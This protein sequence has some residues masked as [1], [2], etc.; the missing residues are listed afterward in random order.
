M[1]PF[2]RQVAEYYYGSGTDLSRTCFIFPNRRSMVFFRKHLADTVRDDVRAVPVTAPEMLTMNDFFYRVSGMSPAGR[3]NLLLELYECYRKLY[4]QAEPID[5]FIFWGDVILGDF[6]DVDKYLADPRP[7]FTNVAEFKSFD[8]IPDLSETQRRALENFMTHFRDGDRLKVD[9]HSDNPAVKERFVRI[10]DIMYP[11]YVNFNDSLRS[12][13]MAYEGMVYRTFAERLKSESA[14]DILSG[15]FP[16]TDLFVFTG[17]NAL[18]E[19]EKRV[20]RKMRDAG[21]A[22]FCW[23]YSSDMITDRLNKSSMFMSSNVTEFPQAFEPDGG[24][25]E[26]RPEIRVLSVPSSTGQAK[27]VPEILKEIAAAT[28]GGNMAEVGRLDVPGADTAI[29]IPDETMLMPLVNTIPEEISSVNVTMGYPMSGSAVYGLMNDIASLQVHLRKRSG[30]W[31]FYHKQVWSILSSGIIRRLMDDDGRQLAAKI[32]SDAKYYIPQQDLSG[33]WPFDLIF[34]PVLT[35]PNERSATAVRS[36]QDYQIR[37]L[38]GIGERLADCPDM[39]LETHFAKEYYQSVNRLRSLELEMLPVTYIRLLQQLVGSVSVPFKGEPLKGLQIMGPL[40]TRSL[41]FSNLIVLSCNEGVFPSRNVSSS[42]IPPELRKGFGLPTYENQDAVWAY[43]FFRMIQRPARVWLL[44]DSRTEGLKSGE[45]SRYIK[46]LE[47]QYR[48]PSLSRTVVR[49]GINIPDSSKPIPKTAEDL[50]RIRTMVY[51]ASSLQNWLA[52]PAK[53]YYSSVRRLAPESE[54][55]ESL[56]SGMIGNVFHDTMYALY[57]GGE[58]LAPDFEMTRENIVANVKSPLKEIRE[59]YIVS[60]LKDFSPVRAKIRALVCR[61]LNSDEVTGR[62]LVVED[63]ICQYVRKTLAKDLELVRRSASG[64]IRILGLEMEKYWKFGDYRFKG[65]IDRMDSIEPGTV[66]IVDYKTGKVGEEE[67]MIDASNAGKVAD[68]LFAP[69]SKNRPK[70]ALQL[71][72]Y[73]KFVE[74]ETAGM[75]VENVLYPVPKLFTSDILS[76]EECKE[77]NEIVQGRLEGVFRDI[78]DPGSGFAMTEDTSVCKYCD[79]RKICGR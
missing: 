15:A 59:D 17:L 47:Y 18:N 40:E 65:Y 36:M 60:L 77:F 78:S 71:F 6:D 44:Y 5:D 31:T 29:V 28:T 13:G 48:Y 21:I 27:Y 11:L 10:W 57:T 33:V 38:S 43:Y 56:D 62:N 45:E 52:C 24:L 69:V 20:M 73:D 32:K 8:M 67:V 54:V 39:A 75:K 9:L 4:S 55:A 49:N 41:D 26:M 63:V 7:L 50:E 19:C 68:A 37:I 76:S 3:V 35:D 14:T 61:E 30:G 25:R 42:F 12:K 70:I 51:S 1:K 22:G 16:H 64:A 2:L 23:D 72:L 46:Q 53:F 79:F 34:Q 58:A 74:K 66:R